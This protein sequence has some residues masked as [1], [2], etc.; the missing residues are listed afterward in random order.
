[1]S[2]FGNNVFLAFAG[3]ALLTFLGWAALQLFT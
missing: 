1:V 3:G 2:V